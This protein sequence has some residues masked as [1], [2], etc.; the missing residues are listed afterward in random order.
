ME[1]HLCLIKILTKFFLMKIKKFAELKVET[2]LLNVKQLFVV[3]LMLLIV[4]LP[5]ELNLLEKS[6]ELFVWW[7]TLSLT[8]KIFHQFKSFYHKN[9]LEENQTFM[10]WW[11]QVYIKSVKMGSMSVLLV[12]WLK[13]VE[14]LKK[15]FQK[16]LTLLDQF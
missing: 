1:E 12:E 5:I 11:F 13:E 6:L 3:H 9:K 7:I 8:L 14:N 15:N 16:L 2:K 4:D 10:L